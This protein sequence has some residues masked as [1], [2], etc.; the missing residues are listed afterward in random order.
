MAINAP[1]GAGKTTLA[2]M[3]A[4]Q[5]RQRPKDRGEAPHIICWF[6]AWMHDD[7]SNLATAFISEVGRTANLSRTRFTRILT[8]LPSS[9]LE[10]SSRKRR[11]ITVGFF[12]LMPTLLVSFWLGAHLQRLEEHKKYEASKLE[13]YQTTTTVTK[14]ESGKDILNSEAKTQSK[15]FPVS[16]PPPEPFVLDAVDH[17]LE[18]FLSRIIILGALFTAIAG[19]LGGLAKIFT[20]TPLGGFIESPDKAAE[21]GAIQSAEKQ[22]SKLIS[23]ARWRGNRFVVFIDDIERCKP[24]RSVEVLDAVNQLMSHKGV[25]VVFL[26]DMSAVAAA[27]QLKYKDLAEIFVPSAGIA[28]TGADRGK[29]AFGRLYLQKIVQFQFDLPIPPTSKIRQFMKQMAD[30]PEAKGGRDGRG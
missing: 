22:L 21:A 7:A 29:E 18:N 1:W 8:P 30:T 14:D 4:E 19:I 24:P 23:Q 10:P 27:A 28:L 3:I 2:N 11:K 6:N 25:V 5:L 13:A 26:G 9:L 20:A 15:S 16:P 17:L 12:I